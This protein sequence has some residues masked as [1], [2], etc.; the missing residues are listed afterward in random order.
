[1]LRI[2]L[3]AAIPLLFANAAAANCAG[4]V[5]KAEERL[6][7][8][9]EPAHSGAPTESYHGEPNSKRDAGQLLRGAKDLSAEGKEEACK[10]Q[11]D[12]AKRVLGD[13]ESKNKE[14]EA[15][16]NRKT[17]EIRD[18]LKG[19]EKPSDKKSPKGG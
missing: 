17:D 4:E 14:Q 6:A 19:G 2:T 7:A 13:L 10:E 16:R 9:K 5:G 11:L 12:Q 8:I 1:M 3:L 18:D 15:L